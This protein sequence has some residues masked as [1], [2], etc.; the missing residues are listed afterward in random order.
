[1]E[2]KELSLKK[3]IKSDN[4]FSEKVKLNIAIK[5][6]EKNRNEYIEKINM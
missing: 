4:S 3:Q 5:E 1:M 6:N 2:E